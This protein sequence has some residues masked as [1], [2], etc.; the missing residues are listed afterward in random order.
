MAT[1]P[2][3]APDTV[4]PIAPPEVPLETP[5]S[6]PDEIE[7]PV[8]DHDNPGRGPIETPPPPD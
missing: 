5:D 7:P 8:P 4:E 6:V 2:D 3:P 1:Q